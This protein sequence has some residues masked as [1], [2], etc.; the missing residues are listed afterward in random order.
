MR[1]WKTGSPP[2]VRVS[3]LLRRTR[4]YRVLSVFDT[5]LGFLTRSLFVT[6]MSL[7]SV[8]AAPRT[9]YNIDRDSGQGLRVGDATGVAQSGSWLR[10]SFF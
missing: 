1:S 10:F 5:L 8:G 6:R 3:T 2:R 9:Q 4:V 7:C